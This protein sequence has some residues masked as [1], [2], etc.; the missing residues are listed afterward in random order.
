MDKSIQLKIDNDH[1][2]NVCKI[3]QGAECC[4]YLTVAGAH[5]WSCEKYSNLGLLIDQ[6]FMEGRMVAQGN[7]CP[8]RA[9]LSGD[10]SPRFHTLD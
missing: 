2:R 3:G 8:G 7:N 1:A 6:R 5:G 4:R 10:M 9:S